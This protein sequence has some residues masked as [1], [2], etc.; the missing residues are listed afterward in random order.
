MWVDIEQVCKHAQVW[1]VKV[2]VQKQCIVWGAG[3]GARDKHEIIATS[4]EEGK[5]N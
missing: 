1:G 2:G 3:I 5:A 4:L